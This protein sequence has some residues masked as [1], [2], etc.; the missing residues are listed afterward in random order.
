MFVSKI[1]IVFTK[2]IL[3]IRKYINEYNTCSLENGDSWTGMLR[4]MI[5]LFGMTRVDRL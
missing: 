1:P 4:S 5:N 2:Y 3:F